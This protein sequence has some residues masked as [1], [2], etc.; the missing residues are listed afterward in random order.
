MTNTA[1]PNTSNKNINNC[2]KVEYILRTKTKQNY[3][4]KLRNMQTQESKT[5]ANLNFQETDRQTDRQTE[6]CKIIL[7]E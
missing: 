2:G 1:T 3:S 7:K 5:N 4:L 6:N